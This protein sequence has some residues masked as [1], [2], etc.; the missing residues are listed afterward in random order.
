MMQERESRLAWFF[1]HYASN[2]GGG[3][4]KYSDCRWHGSREKTKDLMM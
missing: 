3:G 4:N 2:Y 1:I